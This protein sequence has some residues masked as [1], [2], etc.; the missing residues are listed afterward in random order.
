MRTRAL[1]AV[2]H[3]KS[4]RYCLHG[5][6]LRYHVC[7]VRRFDVGSE[8]R[9][10]A[11]LAA[12]SLPCISLDHHPSPL[13]WCLRRRSKLAIMN[14]CSRSITLA[15]S[16]T[17]STE[18]YSCRSSSVRVQACSHVHVYM[19]PVPITTPSFARNGRFRLCFHISTIPRLIHRRKA[20]PK[21]RLHFR[22]ESPSLRARRYSVS[23]VSGHSYY[24]LSSLRRPASRK[25]LMTSIMSLAI[26]TTHLSRTLP[27][28][29]ALRFPFGVGLGTRSAIYEAEA[30]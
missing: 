5:G 15:K 9:C 17:S 30:R 23:D 10:P 2:I 21:P 8:P 24:S 14:T 18:G 25:V 19:L 22:F 7:L 27:E 26:S 6:C 11:F 16:S 12:F 28:A 3:L 4:A 13:P 1:Q 20:L 29:S